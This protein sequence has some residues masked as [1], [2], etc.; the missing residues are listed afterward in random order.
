MLIGG[1]PT[2]GSG[3]NAT[4]WSGAKGG[5]CP[6][7]PPKADLQHAYEYGWISGLQQY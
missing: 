4:E 5:P 1:Q 3:S 2:S 6:E 7:C